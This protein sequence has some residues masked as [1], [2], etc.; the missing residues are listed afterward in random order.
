ML[1][2]KLNHVS[3]R[4]HRAKLTLATRN[5]TV[6]DLC[7][8]TCISNLISNFT[9]VTPSDEQH[10]FS[11]WLRRLLESV[12]NRKL[13]WYLWLSK[14]SAR[15]AMRNQI[16]SINPERGWLT[17]SLH[18]RVARYY[19][20]KV[21]PIK[22]APCVRDLYVCAILSGRRMKQHIWMFVTS[23][24]RGCKNSASL[25]DVFCFTN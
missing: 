11:L 24:F 16:M 19:L 18:E 3:K 17:Q 14:V 21:Y 23:H 6:S 10:D 15:V 22:Y 20:H 9:T 12:I 7:N 5:A 2:L 13:S 25:C 4:G 1:G 8:N